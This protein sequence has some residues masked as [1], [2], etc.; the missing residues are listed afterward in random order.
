VV[1][2]NIVNKHAQG[3]G[4]G[5]RRELLSELDAWQGRPI[6]FFEIAP[7]NWATNGGRYAVCP[8]QLAAPMR[9]MWL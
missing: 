3:A 2:E 9:W 4:L 7:E 6:D 5:F 8:Y 1:L